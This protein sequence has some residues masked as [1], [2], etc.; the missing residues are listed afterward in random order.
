MSLGDDCSV[1]LRGGSMVTIIT[2]LL[3]LPG[4]V[5]S[6]LALLNMLSAHRRSKPY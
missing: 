1:M 3:A 4:A 6:T 5:L 2:I